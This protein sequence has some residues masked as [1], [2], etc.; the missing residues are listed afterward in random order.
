MSF[1]CWT[2][3]LIVLIFKRNTIVK[4]ILVT[5]LMLHSLYFAYSLLMQSLSNETVGSVGSVIVALCAKNTITEY[6]KLSNIMTVNAG[7]EL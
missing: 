4:V 2:I 6:N 3:K 1:T 5:T 7:A